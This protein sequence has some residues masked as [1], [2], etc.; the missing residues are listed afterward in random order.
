MF[1]LT[2]VLIILLL[3]ISGWVS[4]TTGVVRAL[5]QTATNAQ[6]KPRKR[7]LLVGISEYCRDPTG[8]QCTARGNDEARS[9]LGQVLLTLTTGKLGGAKRRSARAG[10]NTARIGAADAA[11]MDIPLAGWATA[12]ITFQARPPRKTSP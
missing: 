2:L 12:E 6:A 10:P 7:A 4:Q 3:I 9:R 8:A 11:K 1:R 5:P